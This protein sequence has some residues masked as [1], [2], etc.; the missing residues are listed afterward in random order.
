MTIQRL[1]SVVAS[2]LVLPVAI[3]SL[4]CERPPVDAEQIG[5][6]GVAME[7]VVNPRAREDQIEANQVPEPLPAVD[8][9]SPP[10]SEV[11]QNVQVLSHLS[12][13][14]FGRLMGAIT[15]WVSPT[16]GC[17][18][19]H[20]GG[21]FAKDDMY[22]KTVSRRMIQ[23][24]RHINTAWKDHVGD[25]GVTCYTCHRGQPVPQ[26]VWYREPERKR[27]GRMLGYSAGQNSPGTPVGLSSL[28]LDPFAA[29]LEAKAREI[30]VQSGNALPADSTRTIKDTE[31][32]YGF[33]VHLSN[34]LGVNC[35]HCH[36]S[37]AFMPWEESTPARVKAWHGIRM[38]REINDEY[39]DSLTDVFPDNRKGPLG[40]VY[41]VNCETCH[42][43]ASKP[44][45]GV[46][47]LADYPGLGP[48]PKSGE[49]ASLQDGGPVHPQQASY[50][51][52]RRALR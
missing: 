28:P 7:Q 41:K 12:S 48:G 18:Y 19:C 17:L 1:A 35:T 44:L 6:R 46:S 27:P 42:Q 10:S 32:T 15:T 4:G 5:F 47:M 52:G 43:G 8:P 39:M 38:V 50:P 33:M 22:T 30:R 2:L 40:D 51:V 9:G 21:N 36:N 11:Y 23:M 25:V 16:Q 34:A 49:Q 26:Y 31:W 20:G 45:L 14:Q 37:R 13:G 3:A 29:F 24:T